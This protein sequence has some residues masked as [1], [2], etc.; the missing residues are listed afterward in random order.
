MTKIVRITA[1]EYR[2]MK[3]TKC[4]YL[5][6]SSLIRSEDDFC[7]AICQWWDMHMPPDEHFGLIHIPNEGKRSAAYGARMRDMGL[8]KG[9]SDYLISQNGTPIVWIEAKHDKNDLTKE[10]KQFKAYVEQTFRF[11]TVRTL[12]EWEAALIKHGVWS[13]QLSIKKEQKHEKD[14]RNKQTG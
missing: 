11:E 9:V 1:A 2:T 7:M 8:R 10:Q 6:D 14:T 4:L 3:P 5:L 12:G 13:G